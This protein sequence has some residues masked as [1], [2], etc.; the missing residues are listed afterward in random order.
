MSEAATLFWLTDRSRFKLATSRCARARY[1]GNHYGPTGYGI[2]TRSESLPLATGK[3]AHQGL[4]GFLSHLKQHDQL[5]DLDLTR[6]II[7]GVREAYEARCGERGFRTGGI[8]SSEQTD[9]TIKEQSALISGLLWA[10]RLKFLPWF[11]EQYRV[12]EV[13]Q[14]RLHLL[15]CACGAGEGAP[16]ALHIARGC[17]GRALMLRTDCLAARRSGGTL[18]YFEAKTT[19]WESDAWAEQWET[20]PQLG[21]GTIDL[22][23]RYGAEVNELYILTL[24]K[25]SRRKDK[26]DPDQRK[27]QSSALCYGYCKPGNPPFAQ[28]DWKP[29]YE[30][31]DEAGETKRVSRQHRKRGVWELP[32]SDWSTWAAYHNQDPTM[33][34]EE[35]WVRL[36]PPSVLD[37]VCFLL[38][39]MNRQDHQIA[40]MRRS[41]DAEE[42]RWQ[43]ILW[44]LYEAQLGGLTWA[45][46]EFQA[47]LDRLI[48]RS[49]NC[50]P[51]GKEHQCEFVPICHRETSWQ[52]PMASGRYQPRLPHHEPELQQAIARGLLPETAAEVAEEER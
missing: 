40:S 49:W 23:E 12:L 2:T 1:L 5:P 18:A 14:E 27:R 25:G 3:S 50:R 8:L 35:F 39:P 46:E 30:W 38:G 45:G 42:E 16:I 13:E 4:E 21:L 22:G 7:A 24:N 29:S 34:P 15:S 51:Y 44:Q 33:T 28:D 26:Y 41:M 17:P 11:H 47:L 36:L 52:D 37:K 48:P 20:D 31:I 9:E 32:E 6:A 43:S 19:G 10:I